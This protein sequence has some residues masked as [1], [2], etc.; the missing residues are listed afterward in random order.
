[1]KSGPKHCS[2]CGGELVMRDID[3]RP[4][5]VCT[6]CSAISYV[7]PIPASAVVVVEDGKILLVRRAIEPK[8]GL[9]SL[10]AGFIEIDETVRECAV[11]EAKE[12]TGLDVELDGIVDVVTVFDD[13]RYVCLLVVFA[14][15]AVGGELAPGDDAAEAGTF[16]LDE[17]PPIA[18]KN[19]RRIIENVLRSTASH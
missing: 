14:G 17:L 8:K 15:H 5:A 2:A 6:S 4:R 9:W 7:N 19:H 10:P 18:F 16:G 1:M 13:P 11:R 3:G 12:E